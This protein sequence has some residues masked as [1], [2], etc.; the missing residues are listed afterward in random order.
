MATD[1]SVNLIIGRN[2]KAKKDLTKSNEKS[3]LFTVVA[4]GV[5]RLVCSWRLGSAWLMY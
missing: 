4:G 5:S 2:T 3:L 1:G